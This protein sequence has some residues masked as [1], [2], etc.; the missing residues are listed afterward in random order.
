MLNSNVVKIINQK[1]KG[2]FELNFCKAEKD[3]A[4][5]THFWAGCMVPSHSP[6]SQT[7]ILLCAH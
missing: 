4:V 3:C 1:C 7:A 6:D 2:L 5:Q